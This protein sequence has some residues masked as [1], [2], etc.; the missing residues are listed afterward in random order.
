MGK[1]GYKMGSYKISDIY[2]GA[3]STLDPPIN[4][5]AQT[6]SFGMTTDGRVANIL[7]EFSDRLA[8]GTKHIEVSGASGEIFDAIPK[9]QL[10]EVHRL[11]KLTG[12]EVSLH[13]PVFEASGI[14]QHGYDESEREAAE[15]RVT[16]ALLRAR[17][18]NPNGNIPV[19]F[20]STSGIPGSQLLPYDKR[21]KGEDGTKYQK[22]FVINRDSG[23][24]TA[25]EPEKLYYPG[26]EV[27]EEYVTPE[28]RIESLNNTEWDNSLF[29]IE[30]NRENAERILKDVH[31][32]FIERAISYQLGRV[33]PNE[34]SNEEKLQFNKVIS[35]N[36]FIKQAKMSA[37]S[38]FSKAYEIA[39]IEKDE[40][41]MNELRNF[42]KRYGEIVGMQDK[43]KINAQR[44]YNPMAHV[45][46]LRELMQ[47]LGGRDDS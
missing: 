12:T 34:I 42:S 11:S 10:K 38:L 14:N 3:G 2:Q 26:G 5:Y 39:T 27:R 43:Q 41:R 19:T 4:N 29:Q 21:T 7:K 45:N 32:I 20:H 36:E 30:V 23:K 15:R 47:E 22:L 1:E 16:D 40:K 8:S 46:A 18:L 13:A 6:K 44:Y 28:K 37:N 24:M 31:P 33:N 35:A 25:L 17:E 9:Q